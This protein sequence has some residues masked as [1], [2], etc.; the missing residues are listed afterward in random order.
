MKT[1]GFK[2]WKILLIFLIL[3]TVP[4]FILSSCKKSYD[5]FCLRADE[6]LLE[7]NFQGTVLV[8]KGKKLIFEK[9]YGLAD[10][11][12]KHAEFLTVDSV[13]EAGSLTKQM[14]AACIM[15]QVEKNNLSLEDSLDKFFP[16]FVNGKEITIRMLLNMRSGLVDHINAP[17]EFYSAK[18][19][20]T[21]SKR[22]KE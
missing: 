2:N 3:I 5:E 7:M 17:D 22:E 8:A 6:C 13:Y 12:A 18:K 10:E 20:R 11:K 15:Q 14:T 19:Y 9:A 21:L 16:D 1:G 4:V